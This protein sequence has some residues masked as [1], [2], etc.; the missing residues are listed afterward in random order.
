MKADA[1]QS[2]TSGDPGTRDAPAAGPTS[3][4]SAAEGRSAFA[5]AP[6]ADGASSGSSASL[7]DRRTWGD[8]VHTYYDRVLRTALSQLRRRALAEEV[9]QETFV[10]AY[11][12]RHLY[13]G[14]GP[15]GSW[16]YRIA[17]NLSRDVLRRENIRSHADLNHATER[18]SDDL[19]PSEVM[20][21]KHCCKVLKQELER[22]PET[23]RR[24]FEHTVIMGYSYKEAAEIEGV[25]EGTI[26]SRVARTRNQLARK[27]RDL[28]A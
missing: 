26:A 3:A 12:K 21:H 19:H 18:A 14:Q 13:D 9:A 23:M 7:S 15:L 22:M 24:A 10:R 8:V 16:L 17:V 25:S 27:Y 1:D 5:R 11:E 4:S 20:H 28:D 6:G 2:S